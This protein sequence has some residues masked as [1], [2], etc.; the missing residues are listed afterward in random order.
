[1]AFLYSIIVSCLFLSLIKQVLYVCC[2]PG[3]I[4]IR[5]EMFTIITCTMIG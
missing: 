5:C 1:M 2:A 3:I 4:L